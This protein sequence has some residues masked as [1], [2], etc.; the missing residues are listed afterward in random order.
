MLTAACMAALVAG[1]GGGGDEGE[2]GA[3]APKGT[4][5]R[6]SEL[7][8]AAKATKAIRSY[9]ATVKMRS[10]VA[11]A[12]QRFDGVVISAVDARSGRIFG[13]FAEAGARET[14]LEAITQGATQ[15]VRSGQLTRQL[16]DGKRWLRVE[17]DASTPSTLT[18][19]EFVTF[20]RDSGSARELGEEDV[21]GEPTTHVTGELDSKAIAR[22]SGVAA[23][24][25]LQRVV[26]AGD[27]RATVDLWIGEDDRP[28][29]M[30]LTMRPPKPTTGMLRSTLEVLGYDVD[31]RNAAPPPARETVTPAELGAP[32]G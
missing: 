16:P 12:A 14:Q 18:P 19:V 4:P 9:R 28:R 7:D 30:Q 29:R 26:G 1:C 24:Q 8:A 32:G 11:G 20:L 6:S 15:W 31:L 22:T 2:R 23:Q 3:P 25:R 21:R 17:G 13:R 10:D 5:A 27:F